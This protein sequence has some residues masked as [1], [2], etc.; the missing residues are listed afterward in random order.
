M[1]TL[2]FPLFLAPP[3]HSPT[4]NVEVEGRTPFSNVT[5]D[6]IDLTKTLV[7]T[8]IWVVMS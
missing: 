1:Q 3:I 7:E 5:L 8:Q 4:K 2:N 6:V